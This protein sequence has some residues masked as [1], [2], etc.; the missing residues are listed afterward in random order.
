MQLCAVL[1]TQNTL[2]RSGKMQLTHRSA[3]EARGFC[4]IL[5]QPQVWMRL[6]KSTVKRQR[7]TVF[8]IAVEAITEAFSR[9]FGVALLC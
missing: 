9:K 8:S 6:K 7:L 3:G 2:K 1:H 5:R 4:N